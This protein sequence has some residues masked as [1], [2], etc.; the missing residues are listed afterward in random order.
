M[1]RSNS[2]LTSTSGQTSGNQIFQLLADAINEHLPADS[3][4]ESKVREIVA[5]E[6]KAA[7]LPRPIEV[8]IAGCETNLVESAHHQL[9]E[10]LGLVSEG[11]KNILMVGPEDSGGPSR[12]V[13]LE[14]EG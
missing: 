7:R 12:T 3:I 10:V 1:S 9:E 4:D 6:V 13:M 8:R 11:H 2:T 14:G 5:D